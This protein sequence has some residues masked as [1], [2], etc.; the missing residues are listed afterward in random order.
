MRI[1]IT[2][3]DG[4]GRWWRNAHE[5]RFTTTSRRDYCRGR[6]VRRM[7]LLAMRFAPM[8]D[9]PLYSSSMARYSSMAL[10]AKPTLR[11][12]RG[13]TGLPKIRH[14][15]NIRASIKSSAWRRS[16]STPRWLAYFNR[17]L[18]RSIA[19]FAHQCRFTSMKLGI[20]AATTRV[21]RR[22]YIGNDASSFTYFNQRQMK[23]RMTAD[24][25]KL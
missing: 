22:R 25:D 5:R 14:R 16:K 9:T 11:L 20:I 7:L 15:R 4:N 3:R 18:I 13:A 21:D 19:H 8:L 17:A 24:D 1:F 23:F 2:L 6:H 10:L 12:K